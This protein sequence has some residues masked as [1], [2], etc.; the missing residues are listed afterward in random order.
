MP[1]G[2][3]SPYPNL[4]TKERHKIAFHKWYEKYG[5]EYFTNWRENNKKKVSDAVKR[6]EATYPE[7]W[8]LIK[9]LSDRKYHLKN[10]YGL[11]QEQFNEMIKLQGNKCMICQRFFYSAKHTR[12]CID[13]DHKTGKLRGIVCDRCNVLLGTAEDNV[14]ILENSIEYLRGKSG[15]PASI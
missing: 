1:K 13:H 3:F 5:K 12:P 14:A 9:K 7:K 4:T 6:Y 11:T 2:N 8:R 15:M 10:R